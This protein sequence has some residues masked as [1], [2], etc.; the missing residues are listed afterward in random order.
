M[1]SET[2]D[3]LR[4]LRDLARELRVRCDSITMAVDSISSACDEA[5]G[6]TDSDAVADIAADRMQV[7]TS[8]A[9]EEAEALRR[10]VRLLDMRLEDIWMSLD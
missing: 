5:M 10:D 3:A 8:K 1:S 4:S 7:S 2:V 9:T 6:L